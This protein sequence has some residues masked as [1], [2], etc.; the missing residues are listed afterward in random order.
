MHTRVELHF[1]IYDRNASARRRPTDG[2]G[3]LLGGPLG[4]KLSGCNGRKLRRHCEL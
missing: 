1:H 4:G 2:G 3:W